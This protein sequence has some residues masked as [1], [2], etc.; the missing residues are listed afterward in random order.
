MKVSRRRSPVP[1]DSGQDSGDFFMRSPTAVSGPPAV[2][3]C[4]SINSNGYPSADIGWRVGIDLAAQQLFQL[5]DLVFVRE[6]TR[7]HGA[8]YGATGRSAGPGNVG[9]QEEVQIL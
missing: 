6:A 7:R 1:G 5:V 3:N 8:T 4:Y 2:G 9:I